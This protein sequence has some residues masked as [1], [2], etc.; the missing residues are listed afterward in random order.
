MKH[1]ID[2]WRAVVLYCDVKFTV[3]LDAGNFL[4][5]AKFGPLSTVTAGKALSKIMEVG[6]CLPRS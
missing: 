1:W 5:P 2:S 6:I 4:L 3:E